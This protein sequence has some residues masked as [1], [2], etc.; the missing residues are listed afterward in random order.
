MSGARNLYTAAA[1]DR[2]LKPRSVAIVGASAKPGA[3]GNQVVMGQKDFAGAVWPIN[4]GR[5][6]ICGYKAYPDLRALPEAPD[7]V[8]LATPRA[9]IEG[10]IEECAA[11]GAG[12]VVVLAS[13]F[14]EMEDAEHAA[15]QER[16]AAI[17]AQHGLPVLGPNCIGFAN[18]AHGAYMTF[19]PVLP[20]PEVTGRAIGVVTQSGALGFALAQAAV[21]GVSF[22]HILASGNS[23]DI[24]AADFVSYLA[25][26]PEC[27]VI[28]A[29]IEG[30]KHSQ[31]MVQA[32]RAA[33]EAG[34]PLIL[35]AA[36][37]SAEGALAARSHTG[38][39]A[40]TLDPYRGDLQREGVVL[41]E[42]FD[43]LVEIAA[44]F[45]KAPE[46]PAANGVAAIATSGGAAIFA[47]DAAAANGIALPQPSSE[48]LAELGKHIPD[49]VTI[50]NPC[51][52]TAQNGNNPEAFNDCVRALAA[53]DLYGAMVVPQTY[54]WRGTEERIGG[55]AAVADETAKPICL[56]W[57][58]EDVGGPSTAIVE[59]SNLIL[60]RSM[61]RCFKALSLWH[62]RAAALREHEFTSEEAA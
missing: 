6:E 47:A 60:F 61:D 55:L 17:A 23:C 34:K 32:A 26:A 54:S 21:R 11:V 12:G 58:S 22:S 52:V 19:V 50:R 3:I 46:T 18:V 56:V 16:I 48:V 36:A 4:P 62:Q 5:D 28:V 30:L 20:K 27:Q 7:C 25:G 44:F 42:D 8:I 59:R 2:M 45:A 35:C 24:D 40:G 31:R 29:V 39:I 13:G 38:S 51:D 49:F 1:L 43:R 33:R 53:S 41:V 57:M 14:G 37:S 10:L 15:T 9:S